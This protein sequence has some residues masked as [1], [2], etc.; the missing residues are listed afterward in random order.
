MSRI[1]IIQGHPDPSGNHLCHALADAYARGAGVAG[2]D[3]R[4]IEVA[5]LEIPWLRTKEAFYNGP[6]PETLTLCQEV[7]GRADHLVIVYPLW[8]GTMPAMLKAFFEQVLRPGFAFGTDA[9]GKKWTKRLK[10][11]SAR[12]VVTMGM[13]AFVYRWYFAAHSLKM[14][15]R[16]I[17]GFCGIGPVRE[18]LYG[19]VEAASA[20]KRA[21]WLAAMHRLGRRAR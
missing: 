18:T 8:L 2:H 10:G 6:L 5:H 19:M 17:L 4:R 14:L 20:G 1:A 16:N 12:I 11:K 21:K 7:I 15:E 3:V 13:P 9:T